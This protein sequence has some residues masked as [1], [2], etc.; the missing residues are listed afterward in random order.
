MAESEAKELAREKAL[1]RKLAREKALAR[2]PGM[3]LHR[4]GPS[5]IPLAVPKKLV[6][7]EAAGKGKLF[8]D[9]T[10]RYKP[11]R[12]RPGAS[13]RQ[14]PRDDGLNFNGPPGV[15]RFA[16]PGGPRMITE[17]NLVSRARPKPKARTPSGLA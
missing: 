16:P 1:A 14:R 12:P 9:G 3:V 15:E 8:E 5:G 10:F 17:D 13:G 2:K 6:D 7:L 4:F 11:T